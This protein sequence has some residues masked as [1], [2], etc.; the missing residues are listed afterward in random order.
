MKFSG[1]CHYFQE[2]ELELSLITLAAKSDCIGGNLFQIRKHL[3]MC[4][5]LHCVA[6]TSLELSRKQDENNN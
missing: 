2:G 4:Y 6:R 1:Y 5:Q 3:Q